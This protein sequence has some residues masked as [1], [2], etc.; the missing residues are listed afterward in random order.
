MT[1]ISN[2]IIAQHGLSQDEYDKIC[3]LIA[4]EPNIVELGIFSAMWNEHC[5][6]KSSKLWLKTLHNGISLIW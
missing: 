3:K 2:D 6:Y 5:S 4:R 1:K